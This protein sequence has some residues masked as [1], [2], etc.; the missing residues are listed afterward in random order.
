LAGK[1]DTLC[2][3]NYLRPLARFQEVSNPLEGMSAVR[4]G[5]QG[6]NQLARVV[7][8]SG[9]HLLGIARFK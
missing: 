5:R 9:T 3:T 7:S 4:L 6:V 2:A 8:D 1:P